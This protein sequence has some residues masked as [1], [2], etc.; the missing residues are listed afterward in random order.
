VLPG[1]DMV[2]T[3]LAGRY[4]DFT[5]GASLANRILRQHILP[6]VKSDINPGCPG[7]VMK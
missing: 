1:L 5:T 4:N 7:A 3:I 6:A 2:V